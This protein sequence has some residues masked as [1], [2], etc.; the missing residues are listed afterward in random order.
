MGYYGSLASVMRAAE[1]SKIGGAVGSTLTIL[2]QAH[3]AVL[4]SKVAARPIMGS[5]KS[6]IDYLHAT[7]ASLTVEQIRVLYLN[8]ANRLI[9]DV[10]VATGTVDEAPLYP[11]E[12][13]KHALDTGATGMIVA[14][15]HPSGDPTPSAA[16]V[17]HTQDLISACSALHIRVH[18]HIIIGATGWT[19]MRAA[20]YI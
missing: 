11:R 1:Q 4:R 3:K 13:I 2:A 16:D 6:V 10:I 7:M 14:H 18:D 9:T 19:S 17:A 5:S 8:S 20:K 15:N 12:I